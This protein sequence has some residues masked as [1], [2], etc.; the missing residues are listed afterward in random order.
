MAL[1]SSDRLGKQVIHF[2]T[3]QCLLIKTVE[4]A[5]WSTYT[6]M[7]AERERIYPVTGELGRAKT[8]QTSKHGDDQIMQLFLFLAYI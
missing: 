2:L 5:E 6:K 4:R 1:D 7:R 8:V 3:Q